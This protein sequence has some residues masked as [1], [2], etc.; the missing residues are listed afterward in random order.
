MSGLLHRAKS[1]FSQLDQSLISP[2]SFF[3]AAAF[4]FFFVYPVLVAG[5]E[6]NGIMGAIGLLIVLIPIVAIAVLMSVAGGEGF[7]GSMGAI[8]LFLIGISC[9][10]IS[11]PILVNGF[12]QLFFGVDWI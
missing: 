4:A 5:Y 3:I 2:S 8:A 12:S 7:W 9:L 6:L 10:L 1:R 11:V